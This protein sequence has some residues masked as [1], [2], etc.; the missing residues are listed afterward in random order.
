MDSTD[1]AEKLRAEDVDFDAEETR[2]EQPGGAGA[3]TLVAQTKTVT[4][5]PSTAMSFYACETAQVFGTEVEGGAGTVT[6][7]S[8]TFYALNLGSRVPPS[9][10]KILTTYVSNRWVFRYDG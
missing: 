9:G 10:T 6:A 5:Y 7:G 8:S 2:R 3:A 4:T 1:E